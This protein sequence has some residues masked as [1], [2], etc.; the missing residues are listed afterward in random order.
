MNIAHNGGGSFNDPQSSL[1][2]CTLLHYQTH[3]IWL[4]ASYMHI[5]FKDAHLLKNAIQEN[6]TLTY[7]DLRGCNLERIR[8]DGFRNLIEHLQGSNPMLTLVLKDVNSFKK[9]H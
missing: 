2:I 5:N 9:E 4:N 7:L 3:L 8:T 1:S 6:I